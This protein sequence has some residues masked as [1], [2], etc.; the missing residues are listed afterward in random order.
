[1]DHIFHMSHVLLLISL[2]QFVVKIDILKQRYN[3]APFGSVPILLFRA[4]IKLHPNISI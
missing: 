2:T 3:V 4:L 1:M